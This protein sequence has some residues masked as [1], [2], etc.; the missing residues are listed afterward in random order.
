MRCSQPQGTD[1]VQRRLAAG[2]IKR[3]AQHLAV[4]RHDTFHLLA[5]A[6]HEPLKCDGELGWIKLAEQPAERVV[7]RQAIRQLEQAT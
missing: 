3:A 4:D 7:A 2:A 1:H 6:L 5:K